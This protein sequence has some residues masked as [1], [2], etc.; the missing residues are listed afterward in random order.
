MYTLNI[1][2]EFAEKNPNEHYR[3]VRIHKDVISKLNKLGK[4]K[5]SY[6]DL[7]SRLILEKLKFGEKNAFA[8]K[9]TPEDQRSF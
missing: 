2:E 5:E 6:S 3:S 1:N 9:E 8:G 7:I 4:F